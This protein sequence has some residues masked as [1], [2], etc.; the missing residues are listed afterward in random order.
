MQIS[1]I[2]IVLSVIALFGLE[3][4]I[5][6]LRLRR[7][8]VLFGAVWCAGIAVFL[9]FVWRPDYATRVSQFI[10]VGRGVDAALYI[11]VALLFYL[12]LRILIRLE[13]Q[14]DN[15]TRL[16]SEIALLEKKD[17]I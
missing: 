4:V 6:R 11:A 1:I 8:G 15:I 3:R 17:K 5:A 2:Q 10:G 9:L 13:R 7:M 14:E 16:V 12:V